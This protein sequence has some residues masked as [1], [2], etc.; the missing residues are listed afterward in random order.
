MVLMGLAG[1]K[2]AE[3]C[4]G[5]IAIPIWTRREMFPCGGHNVLSLAWIRLISP[6][7]AIQVD[8]PQTKP[9]FFLIIIVIMFLFF[10]KR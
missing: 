6:T 1:Q 9:A 5:N 10:G 4:D 2:Y 7:K 3:H 8:S